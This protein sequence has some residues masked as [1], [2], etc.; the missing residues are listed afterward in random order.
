MTDH[1]DKL[2]AAFAAEYEAGGTPDPGKFIAQAQAGEQSELSDRI[3]AYLD[4]APADTWD[5]GAYARSRTRSALDSWIAESAAEQAAVGWKKLLPDLRNRAE[6]KRGDL[7][8]KLA[9]GLGFGDREQVER[10][11]SYLHQM[12][13]EDLDPS[14]VSDRVLDVLAG[15]VGSSRAALRAAGDRSSGSGPGAIHSFAR[16]AM[17]DAD[18][19]ADAS[20][21]AAAPASGTPPERD[22][23]DELFLGPAL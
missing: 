13:H 7:A 18:Y 4:D 5:P 17:P 22:E 11:H 2:L 12:E 21:A 10:V 3:D 9:N 16:T 20:A 6:I 14:L 19:A 8:T 15:L 23:L 1:L